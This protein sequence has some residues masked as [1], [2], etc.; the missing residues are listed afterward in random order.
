MQTQTAVVVSIAASISP[1]L[2]QYP[3]HGALVVYANQAWGI[4]SAFKLEIKNGYE[5]RG[6][7][8]SD[9]IRV[10]PNGR[11][12]EV[13]ASVFILPPGNYQIFAPQ[14]MVVDWNGKVYGDSIPSVKAHV[15][16]GLMMDVRSFGS[17]H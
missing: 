15:V 9:G 7:R 10:F 3:T 13:Y 5:Q 17:V 16:P 1:R 14:Q 4:V 6:D 11:G 12:S 2:A 8:Y